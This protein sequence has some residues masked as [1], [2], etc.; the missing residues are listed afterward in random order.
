[1]PGNEFSDSGDQ[2]AWNFHY[3]LGVVLESRFVFRNDLGLCL[4]FVVLDNPTYSFFIP[5]ARKPVLLCLHLLF[6]RSR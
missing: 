3:S 4:F 6:L 5:S 1:M 2:F